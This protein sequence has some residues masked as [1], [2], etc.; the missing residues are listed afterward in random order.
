M[1]E[2]QPAENIELKWKD[3]LWSSLIHA[4]SKG[5]VQQGKQLQFGTT[6]EPKF[7]QLRWEIIF[8]FISEGAVC[9]EGMW[10]YELETE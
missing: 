6:Q 7:Q 4:N 3:R 5:L 2:W 10:G 9:T 8:C 1:G